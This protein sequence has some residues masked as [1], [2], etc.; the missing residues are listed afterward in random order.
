MVTAAT[1]EPEGGLRPVRVGSRWGEAADWGRAAYLAL[2]P[3]F[4]LRPWSAVATALVVA[5]AALAALAAVAAGRR[6][7]LAAPRSP[8]LGLFLAY[9]LLSALSTFASDDPAASATEAVRV[10]LKSALVVLT[11]ACGGGDL[12]RVRRLALGLTVGA[13]GLCVVTLALDAA[14]TRNRWGGVTGPGIGYNA[15]AMFLVA[16]T[17]FALLVAATA[18]RAGRLWSAAAAVTTGTLLLTVSRIG[19]AALAA[20]VTLWV[21]L[22]KDGR[23]RALAAVAVGV[24]AFA[25]AATGLRGI[26]QVTDTPRALARS[27]RAGESA[28]MKPMSWRDVATLDGRVEFGWEPAVALIRQHPLAGAGFGSATFGRRTRGEPALAHEHNAVLSVA[29]QSG[30]VT[31]TVYLALLAVATVALVRA[32]RRAGT[33]GFRRAATVAVLAAI[34]AEYVLHGLAEPTN[35]GRMGLL[36][37]ALVGLAVRLCAPAAPGDETAGEDG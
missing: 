24:A 27:A 34:V 33:A 22:V 25:L 18:R 26:G 23:R 31:A 7:A 32:V 35:T 16:A 11:I 14:G 12:R 37:A 8:I 10:L 4:H 30:V 29:V 6:G 17:P 5:A 13:L 36:F 2:L 19:W 20:A 9:L 1:H 28:P 15:I 3:F 21:A